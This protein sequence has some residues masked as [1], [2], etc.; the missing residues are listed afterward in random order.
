MIKNTLRDM[1]VLD[2]PIEWVEEIAA[3][4]DWPLEKHSETHV[5]FDCQ[6]RWGEFTVSF[7]WQEEFQAMQFSCASSLNVPHLYLNPIKDLLFRVNH[8]IWLGH[9]DIDDG[10]QTI[11]F[12]HTSLMRGVNFAGQNYIEDLIDIALAEFDRFYPAFRMQVATKEVANDLM[13]TVLFET[14]GQA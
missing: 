8:K 14:V 1:S 7:L 6:G 2:N 10:D 11:M 9:F 3:E 5:S 4:N 13:N 12:R